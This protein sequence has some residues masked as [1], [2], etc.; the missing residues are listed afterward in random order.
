MKRCRFAVGVDIAREI[1]TE[2]DGRADFCFDDDGSHEFHE[3]FAAI[4]G[5]LDKLRSRVLAKAGK[6]GGLKDITRRES[7]A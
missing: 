2:F 1:E 4:E 6:D 3:E 7:F 5:T